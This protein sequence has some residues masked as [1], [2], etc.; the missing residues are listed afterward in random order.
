MLNRYCDI[1]LTQP[2]K[3]STTTQQ[4]MRIEKLVFKPSDD[5][6]VDLDTSSVINFTDF[7]K[8]RCTEIC[9]NDIK[10]N[11][12]E[13]TARR[14]YETNKKIEGLHLLMDILA[15]YDYFFV[16]RMIEGKQGPKKLDCLQAIYANDQLVMSKQ[17]IV[18][19]GSLISN[20]LTNLVST[21]LKRVTVYKGCREISAILNMK[22]INS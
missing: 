17:E 2:A 15:Q 19:K 11:V 10:S 8:R 21:G 5:G 22:F 13:K 7:I 18:Q 1:V 9:I 16:T 6:T 12:S 3:K 20:Y 14:R 4:Y